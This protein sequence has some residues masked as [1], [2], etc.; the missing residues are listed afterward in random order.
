M[1]TEPFSLIVGPFEVYLAPVGTAFPDVDTAPGVAWSLL[2]EGSKD[3][4]E[5][6][7]T[8]T[9]DQNIEHDN[10]RGLGTTGSR[11]AV[12]TSEDLMIEFT[13]ANL[14]LEQYSYAMNGA[15]VVS[16]P[17]GSGTPGTRSIALHQGADV[18]TFA[19]LVRG[20]SA[21]G[22]GWNC[23][24][25]VPRCY[26][27]D[28]PAPQFNKGEPAGLKFAFRALEDSDAAPGEEFGVL[29]MQDAAAL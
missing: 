3:I 14:T 18:A 6:G 7:V 15:S 26:Q 1:S 22:D 28:N 13:L 2:G 27:S 20:P 21:Y 12:R 23:Q 10:F 25:Q 17:A 11:K 5:D 29:V 9:H 8:V 24:Y 4:T 16:T 19:M